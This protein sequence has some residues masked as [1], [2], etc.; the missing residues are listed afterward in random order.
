M[1]VGLLRDE[2]RHNLGALRV[3]NSGPA[4]SGLLRQAFRNQGSLRYG[5]R[6]L[7]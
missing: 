5:I 1:A 4:M 6:S 3:C 2:G 7:L